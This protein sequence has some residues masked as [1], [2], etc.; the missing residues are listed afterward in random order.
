MPASRSLCIQP[1]HWD[2]VRV[3]SRWLAR[4]LQSKGRQ[5]RARHASAFGQVLLIHDL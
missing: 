5:L 2:D 3:L 4:Q 1:A